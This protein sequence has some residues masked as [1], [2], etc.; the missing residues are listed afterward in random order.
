[1]KKSLVIIL[2]VAIIGG[3]GVYTKSHN[4]ASSQTAT[5]TGQ[6][7]TPAPSQNTA[8]NTTGNSNSAPAGTY[9]DG[10]YTGKLID[11]LYGPVQVRVSV[12]G[13]K[14]TDVVFLNMPDEHGHTQE[15]TDESSPILKQMTLQKQSANIDFVSGATQTSEGYIKSLQSALDQ[16]A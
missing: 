4:S 3:L 5:N 10:T 12:S 9:H 6:T 8:S 11:T 7:T 13:G 14:I 1:M 15:V 16:A 2:A